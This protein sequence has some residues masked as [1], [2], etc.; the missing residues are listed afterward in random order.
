MLISHLLRAAV[1][2][3]VCTCSAA[4]HRAAKNSW[5]PVFN[6]ASL[7]ISSKEMNVGAD[8]LASILSKAAQENRELNIWRQFGHMT[9]DVVGSAAF[10]CASTA[11][12]CHLGVFVSCVS[13]CVSWRKDCKHNV[14]Y[15]SLMRMALLSCPL[16]VVLPGKGLL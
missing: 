15:V 3:P 4:F 9:M 7:E 12:R 2:S 11:L 6:S 16:V 8:R 5:L 14:C 13:A 10:G 1:M